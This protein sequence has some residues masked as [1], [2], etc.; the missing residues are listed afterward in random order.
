MGKPPENEEKM[1]PEYGIAAL[2]K[3]RQKRTLATIFRQDRCRMKKWMM[4]AVAL[5]ISVCSSPASLIGITGTFSE[6]SGS[7]SYGGLEFQDAWIVRLYQTSSSTVN[8]SLGII[9]SFVAST[10]IDVVPD[11]DGYVMINASGP[12]T[13]TDNSFVYSVLFNTAVAPASGD[14]YLLLDTVARNVG[15]NDPQAWYT[16]GHDI[17]YSGAVTFSGQSWQPVS[18]PEPATMGLLGAG[19]LVLALRRKLRK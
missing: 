9:D 18:V 6:T 12:L 7:F 16:P 17:P 11:P 15:A 10:D 1:K 3:N 14:S 19:A 2:T 4:A 5:W 13:F 8:F